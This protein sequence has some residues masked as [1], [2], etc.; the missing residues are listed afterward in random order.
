VFV[1]VLAVPALLV[2]LLGYVVGHGIWSWSAGLLDPATRTAPTPGA[3]TAGWIT[4][5][6]LL[7]GL[8]CATG[9]RRRRRPQDGPP[10]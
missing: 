2:V 10:G 6:L 9:R 3:E 4:G 8:V 5:V 1:L 7:L